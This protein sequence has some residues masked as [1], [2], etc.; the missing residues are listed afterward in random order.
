MLRALF[1]KPC[2]E[3]NWFQLFTAGTDNSKINFICFCLYQKRTPVNLALAVKYVGVLFLVVETQQS[4]VI[5]PL[6]ANIYLHYV[7][8]LW[9]NQWRSG[10]ARG[11]GAATSSGPEIDQTLNTCLK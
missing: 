4:A 11:G 6:L 2:P 10:Y 8:D 3:A 5:S 9:A 1:S 7:L